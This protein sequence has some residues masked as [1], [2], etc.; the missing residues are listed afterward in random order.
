MRDVSDDLVPD[1]ECG[2]NRVPPRYLFSRKDGEHALFDAFEL[3]AMAILLAK[4]LKKL[5]EG[6]RDPAF[7]QELRT[8]TDLALRATKVAARRQLVKRCLLWCSKNDI[9]GPT[10]RICELPRKYAF[11]ICP[12]DATD[13]FFAMPSRV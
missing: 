1:T 10:L 13:R 6:K 8:A 3:Y 9:F 5:A 12:S 2:G 7:M 4:P 11:S